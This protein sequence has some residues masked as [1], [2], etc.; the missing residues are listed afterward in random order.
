[1]HWLPCLHCPQP[2]S[3]SPVRPSTPASPAP[4]SSPAITRSPCARS[5]DAVSQSHPSSQHPLS[6]LVVLISPTNP[7]RHI[8]TLAY[9]S[10]SNLATGTPRPSP[11]PPLFPAP[12]STPATHTLAALPSLPP[13]TSGH[14]PTTFQRPRRTC[15]EPVEWSPNTPNSPSAPSAPSAPCAPGDPSEPHPRQPKTSPRRPRGA[16]PEPLEWGTQHPDQSPRN[17]PP[18]PRTHPQS[19]AHSPLDS[20]SSFTPSLLS[21]SASHFSSLSPLPFPIPL[22]P[23]SSLLRHRTHPRHPREEPAPDA[24]RGGDP[25]AT[26]VPSAPVL[27]R[28][29]HHPEPTFAPTC[30]L[31]PSTVHY[32]STFANP[33]FDAHRLPPPLVPIPNFSHGSL[34][35]ARASL[36]PP[37]PPPA[38]PLASRH[39]HSEPT[40]TSS[41][42]TAFPELP[43]GRE[44]TTNHDVRLNL[45]PC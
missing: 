38:S 28:S 22:T 2:P 27:P 8:P 25:A 7:S 3:R 44:P 13:P 32:L 26:R 20:H 16:C 17:R 9:P 37:L 14:S 29:L 11:F 19:T 30:H 45:R 4:P 33:I 34:L 35:S 43:E 24:I 12:Q 18:R 42:Q 6:Q 5:R 1:M 10:T 23:L 31:P 36:N 15:P 39:R 41:P 21:T 40:A